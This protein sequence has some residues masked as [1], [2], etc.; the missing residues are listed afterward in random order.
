MMKRAIVHEFE[1]IT[2]VGGGEL[3]PADLAEA[4]AVAPKV[5]AVDGGAAAVLAAGKVPEAVIG[6][7]DS[8]PKD[9]ISRIPPDRLHHFEEQ[10]STDFDKAIRNI[11]APLIIGVGFMGARVDHQLAALNV[12]VRRA[13]KTV[14]L[15]S[16]REAIFHVPPHLGLALKAEDTVSLMPLAPV[17]GRSTGLRWPIDGLE[18]APDG[19]IGTSN[20][21]IG[22]VSLSVDRPG[23]IGLIPRQRFEALAQR[24]AQLTPA[25]QWPARAE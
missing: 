10:D 12:L 7:F 25:Q 2:L 19:V 8:L 13:E 16:A 5:V 6:D 11:Q 23:L 24:M 14:I 1:P 22:E 4:C 9:M 20:M 17:T 3:G 21:A 15:L 18:F